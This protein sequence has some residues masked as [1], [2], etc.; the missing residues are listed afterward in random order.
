M[1]V[2]QLGGGAHGKSVQVAFARKRHA[3]SSKPANAGGVVGRLVACQNGGSS[4]RVHILRTEGVLS[5]R[6]ALRLTARLSSC[7]RRSAQQGNEACC[8]RLR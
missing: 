1:V 8:V 6:H 4:G 2:A 3:G 5:E 7:T